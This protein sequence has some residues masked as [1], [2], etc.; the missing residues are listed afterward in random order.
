MRDDEDA[1]LAGDS[2]HDMRAHHI[3]GQSAVQKSLEGC[4]EQSTWRCG[5]R[6][7]C[8]QGGHPERTWEPSLFLALKLRSCCLSAVSSSLAAVS[9]PIFISSVYPASCPSMLSDVNVN[10]L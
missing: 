6:A 8:S 5:R 1:V 4:L 10:A 9:M 7:S 2:R 3:P